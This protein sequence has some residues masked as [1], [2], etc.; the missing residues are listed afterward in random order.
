MNIINEIINN[1]NKFIFFFYYKKFH[2][3]Y[4]KGGGLNE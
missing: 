4:V 3:N 1:F 2:L